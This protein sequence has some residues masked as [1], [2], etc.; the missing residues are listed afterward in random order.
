MYKRFLE[1]LI[2]EV[3]T[4]SPA[5][6]LSGARQVGKSTLSM[7]LFDNY[8]LMD[9]ISIRASAEE[10]P[11]SFIENLPKPVCIDEIQKV[12]GLIEVIKTFIDKDRK[13]GMFLLTGSASVLD[14][15][16]VGDTLA[17]RIIDLVSCFVMGKNN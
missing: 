1:P 6:L 2:R 8:V 17:G 5:V 11:V 16:G 12:P 3:L 14:M 4:I 13:N 15:K 10:D 7:K 9:D